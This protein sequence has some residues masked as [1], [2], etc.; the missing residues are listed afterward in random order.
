VKRLMLISLLGALLATGTGCG[1]GQ[2][3]F[4][5][6]PCA[7][8]GG[9]G[10][11]CDSGGDCG[12]ACGPACGPGL[13]LRGRLTCS[14]C[15]DACDAP[16]GR[17]CRR[18][19]CRSCGTC[20]SGCDDPCA[21]P[22]GPGTCGRIWYRGP[23]SCLFGLMMRGAWCG[24]NCGGR[25]W[26]DFYSDPPD[27]WDPCDGYGNYSGGCSSCGARGGYSEDYDGDVGNTV[28]EGPAPRERI[29]SQSD[30]EVVPAPRPAA[31][32]H[33]ASPR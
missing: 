23:L 20:D 31:Q 11:M 2:A 29:M 26:G 6:R 30:R 9:C 27:C 25:Y 16:C 22:C 24:P 18:P 5:Y 10:G 3:I 28:D 1:L 21:D 32:P 17:P 33:K 19:L 14:D 8:R 12:P 7:M 13:G 4:C 15:G